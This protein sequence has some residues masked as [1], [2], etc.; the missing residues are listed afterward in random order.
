MGKSYSKIRHIQESNVKLEKR[1]IVEQEEVLAQGTDVAMGM[2]ELAKN[3]FNL[4]W[5][6]KPGMFALAGLAYEVIKEPMNVVQTLKNFVNEYKEQLGSSYNQI[7]MN[8]DKIGED[9]SEFSNEMITLV[10]SYNPLG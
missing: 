5:N 4:I 7:I 8:L 2:V 10:K 1:F 9:S 6:A 3:V